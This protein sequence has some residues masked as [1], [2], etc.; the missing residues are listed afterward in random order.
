[1]RAEALAGRLGY[2]DLAVYDDWQ[3]LIGAGTAT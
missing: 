2:A 1:M 3:S